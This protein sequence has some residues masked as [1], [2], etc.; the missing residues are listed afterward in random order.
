MSLNSVLLFSLLLAGQYVEVKKYD[1]KRDA[2]KDIDAAITEAQQTGKHI[3]LVVGGEWCS[4]CHTLDHYF[5]SN[6]G[7]TALRDRNYITLKINWSP[8]NMNEKVL[9]RY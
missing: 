3:L 4:W 1:P 9:S 6:P 8:E 7:L 2:A 5:E